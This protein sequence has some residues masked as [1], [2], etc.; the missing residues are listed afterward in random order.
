MPSVFSKLNSAVLG[1][2][3]QESNSKPP[4]MRA[5]DPTPQTCVDWERACRRYANNKDI[6]ADKV[7]KCML[8]GIEDICFVDW[9]ELDCN[10]MEAMMQEEF[11][12]L[13]HETHLHTGR[14]ILTL[15]S[16][17]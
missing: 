6:P 16:P 13:F 17:T 11:M 3:E 7:V 4:Y 9:I 1:I 12:T 8:D 10:H 14:T 15:P 2:V 5:G